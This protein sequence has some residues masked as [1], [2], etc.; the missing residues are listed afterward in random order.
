MRIRRTKKPSRAVIA[1]ALGG[2]MICPNLFCILGLQ[3]WLHELFYPKLEESVVN[4]VN[5]IVLRNKVFFHQSFDG[6]N[7]G[8]QLT[9]CKSNA[10]IIIIKK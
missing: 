7:N 3:F 5:M 6:R 8:T 1:T 2:Y 10:F 9:L 4:A